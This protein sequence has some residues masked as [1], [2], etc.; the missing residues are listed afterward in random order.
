MKK[1]KVLVVSS[2]GG[3]GKSTVSMQVVTPFLYEKN[4]GEKISF[5]EF[6]DENIDSLSYGGSVLSKRE[7]IDVEEFVI[8]D[9]FL[10]I[11]SQDE[12]ACID[13]GGNKSTTLCLDTLND[14]GMISQIDLAIIPLL[15]GEQDAI[16]AQKV[17]KR[18]KELDSDIKIVFALN[19][20]KNE[21]YVKY[22]F[23]N[24]FG[25]VRGI[26]SDRNALVNILDEKEKDS[27][28]AIEDSDIIK[29][30]RKF[31]MTIYE[32]AVQHRDFTLEF[33][34]A[35]DE[36]DK[37]LIAFKNY[38]YQNAKKYNESTLKNCFV[39]LDSIIKE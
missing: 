23:D 34:G 20:V 26:F 4:D 39:K 29:Y 25:D 22:Q 11:L 10:E 30:S 8:M 19:R 14:S 33:E 31:G 32:I 37:K 28:I 15:D 21:K 13:V 27:Y 17:Y 5:Y 9:K 1:T 6:D 12:Y 38:V 18:L 2:K 24:F 7:S 3:V 36:K 16:N 35:V